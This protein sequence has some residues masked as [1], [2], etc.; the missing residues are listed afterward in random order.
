M[1]ILEIS[2]VLMY[3]FHYDYSK[4]KY[5]SKSKL[6]N[7]QTLMSHNLMYEMSE[8]F[9][10]DFSSNKEMFDVSN[11]STK[12]KCYDNSAKLVLE[13]MQHES[14]GVTI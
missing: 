11:F 6:L 4:N 13:K 3:E 8:D 5:G 9:Y 1:W 14:R 12:S 10:E 7:S 2:K